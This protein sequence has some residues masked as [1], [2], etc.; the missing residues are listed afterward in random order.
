MLEERR[1]E[2]KRRRDAMVTAL[3]TYVPDWRFRVPEG[4]LNHAPAQI[5]GRELR[6]AFLFPFEAGVRAGGLRSMMHAYDDVDGVP[7]VES[8][9]LLACSLFHQM[10]VHSWNA[11]LTAP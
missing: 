5:G 3:R 7:C 11:R 8:H 9:E 10:C 4:G 1:A 6:N 2:A